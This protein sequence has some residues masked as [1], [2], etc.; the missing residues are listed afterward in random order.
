VSSQLFSWQSTCNCLE[1]IQTL[2][3]MYCSGV[4]QVTLLMWQ[5]ILR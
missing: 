2:Y 5:N 3:C 4:V 1:E